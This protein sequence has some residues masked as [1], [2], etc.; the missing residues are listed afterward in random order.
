MDGT[1]LLGEY[2]F[3]KILFTIKIAVVKFNFFHFVVNE[4]L[5]V[6]YLEEPW[7]LFILMFNEVYFK[8]TSDTAL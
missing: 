6:A 4:S 2:L 7:F 8:K 5:W 3:K 1:Q